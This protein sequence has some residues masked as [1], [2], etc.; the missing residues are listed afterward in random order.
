MIVC[1]NCRTENLDSALFCQNCGTSLESAH[2]LTANLPKTK[3]C[4]HC[5]GLISQEAVFC[6]H[7]GRDVRVTP[8]S[9][10]QA[11]PAKKFPLVWGLLAVVIIVAVVIFAMTNPSKAAHNTAIA[12]S[13][14]KAAGQQL[15]GDTGGLLGQLLGGTLGT[16]GNLV[17]FSPF[18]YHN[19][20]VFSTTSLQ[21][22]VISVG[23]L[24][25]VRVVAPV[26]E[27]VNTLAS[28][29]GL[30]AG[31]TV[32]PTAQPAP[33]QAPWPTPT[34]IVEDISGVD[35]PPVLTS[36]AITTA[37][38]LIYEDL[39]V[40]TGALAKIGDTVT[41]NYTGWLPGGVK[42]D[43]T[44][45]RGQPFSFTIGSGQVIKGFDEG[46]QG[47][48]L[49]GTRLL[50]I[51]PELAYGSGGGYQIPADATLTFEIQLVSISP[52][53]AYAAT[54][55][56]LPQ[57]A[58]TA[59]YSST[60]SG[61]IVYTCEVTRDGDI[62]DQLCIVNP[63]GSGQHQLTDTEG[64]AY[65]PGLSPDGKHIVFVSNMSGDHDIYDLDLDTN[66]TKRLTTGLG[67]PTSPRISPDGNLIAFANQKKSV[68][69]LNLMNRDGS[70]QH[71]IY[72]GGGLRPAWSPD[73]S[74]IVF[75][76]DLDGSLYIID[77]NGNNPHTI[78]TAG[79]IGAS[80]SWSPTG[81]YLAI[82]MGDEDK[83]QIYLLDPSGSIIRQVTTEGDNLSPTFSPDGNWIGFLCYKAGAQSTK[84]GEMCIIKTDG[85]GLLK[86]TNNQLLDWL[87][88]WGR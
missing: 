54:S 5:G 88:Y 13:L 40:G 80:A 17:D 59:A 76:N 39:L 44:F 75:Y 31:N 87:P 24:S 29:S 19:Y 50:V 22:Q 20:L 10:S 48:R 53:P 55:T 49:N 23:Y 34:S 9:Q 45:D 43:S 11:E 21:G 38:G 3:N 1:P 66:T 51:P 82:Y 32:Y 42:F 16:I 74:Q 78:T 25:S 56:P 47:L 62:F 68:V 83:R 71:T 84:E 28:L 69:T 57:V 33:T 37:S 64:N 70:N 73:S 63:D 41:L 27:W 36:R 30:G 6:R 79:K 4:P 8:A 52:A 81:N 60:P 58:P 65:Y 18:A 77:V 14:G 2:A 35:V 12:T 26:D 7:C 86:L 46:L 85:T 15:G 72:S 61:K 67:D